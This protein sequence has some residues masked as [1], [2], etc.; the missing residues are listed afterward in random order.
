M[1]DDT[2]NGPEADDDGTPSTSSAHPASIVSSL[3]DDEAPSGGAPHPSSVAY[4][5]MK[6]GLQQAALGGLRPA[7]EE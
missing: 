6:G 2:Y 7:G 5:I 4:K 3:A 1:A